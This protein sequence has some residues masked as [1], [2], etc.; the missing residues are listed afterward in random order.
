ME[1]D[2][3][4][5]QRKPVPAQEPESSEEETTV[6]KPP[7]KR[8]AKIDDEELDAYTPWVDILRVLTFLL[9][10]SC[11]LSYVISGGESWFWGMKHKPNYMTVDY[12][13][14]IIKGPVSSPP[15][16]TMA[17]YSFRDLTRSLP[18]DPPIYLTPDEL[19]NFDGT[20]TEK[21]LY[22]SLNHTIFDVSNGRRIYGPGGSYSVFAGRDASRAFVTGCF[23]DD[24][25][26]D[27]R[28]V[29]LM[30]MP[31]DDPETDAHWTEEEL[32]VK[33][34]Q[35]LEAAKKRAH[36]ALLHWVNFFT[37]SKKYKKVG[38]LVREEGWLEKEPL[39]ELCAPAQ[40]GR[41]KRLVPDV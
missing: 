21:P 10:A 34:V 5:R 27:L 32:A 22:I 9:M 4:V 13:K 20:D 36:D 7:K 29:E 24:R 31:L 17:Y 14:D 38:Y 19:A 33:R 26:A 1:D 37:N 3:T 30:F 2:S 39:R 16:R 28:G 15:L 23:A 25:T 18:Q 40:N 6:E 12:W 8:L 41:R 35:E 11:G